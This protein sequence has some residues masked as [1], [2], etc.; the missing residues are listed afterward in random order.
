MECI[1]SGNRIAKTHQVI[2]NVSHEV[3]PAKQ[4]DI[5]KFNQEKVNKLLD[6]ILNFKSD[7]NKR[8]EAL[9]EIIECMDDVSWLQNLT[10][11]ETQLLMQ[12]LE[13]C[14]LIHR[15]EIMSYVTISRLLRKGIAKD[16]IKEY[17][18][19]VDDM[20][21]CI[22]DLEDRFFN[23]PQDQE[24]LDDLKKLESM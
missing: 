12:C 10:E 3:K 9:N 17:K 7:L 22:Q 2:N 1:A 24:F 4:Q 21:E 8:S 5:N 15:Q 11:E 18:S 14:K 20:K 23:L 6:E 19:V 13:I 16:E